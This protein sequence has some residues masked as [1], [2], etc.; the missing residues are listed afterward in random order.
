MVALFLLA[1]KITVILGAFAFG[2]LLIA[3]IMFLFFT[4]WSE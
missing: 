1:L 2:G 4:D 3:G